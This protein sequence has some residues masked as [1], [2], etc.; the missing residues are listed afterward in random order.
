MST[1]TVVMFCIMSFATGWFIRKLMAAYEI[2]RLIHEIQEINKI[3][4][5]SLKSTKEEKTKL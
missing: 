3:L 1:D 2:G 4:D 5:R